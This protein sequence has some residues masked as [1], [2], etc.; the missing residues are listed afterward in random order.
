MSLQN[1]G[2]DSEEETMKRTETVTEFDIERK[3]LVTC[4]VCRCGLNDSSQWMRGENDKYY[5][6][7]CYQGL[8]VPHGTQG[9]MEICE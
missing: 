4:A 8:L 2:T 3:P 5:C 6:G 9:R 1:P 7:I